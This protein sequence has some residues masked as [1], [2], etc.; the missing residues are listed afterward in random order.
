MPSESTIFRASSTKNQKRDLIHELDGFQASLRNNNVSAFNKL[1]ISTAISKQS[2]SS[3]PI[4]GLDSLEK[5]LT[6]KMKHFHQVPLKFL[7][8]ILDFKKK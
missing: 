6:N 2:E 7:K 4:I 1:G 5:S 3:S 8:F